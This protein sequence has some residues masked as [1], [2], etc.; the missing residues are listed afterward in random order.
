MLRLTG[1]KVWTRLCFDF[2]IKKY[3]KL[4]FTAGLLVHSIS[5]PSTLSQKHTSIPIRI[6]PPPSLTS[7][8]TL[9]DEVETMT[10]GKEAELVELDDSRST[11][12]TFQRIRGEGRPKY[13]KNKPQIPMMRQLRRMAPR[14]NRILIREHL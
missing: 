11:A 4:H 3:S 13:S 12:K 5:L 1:S 14:P 10:L 2:G 6:K 9:G 7:T 8:T